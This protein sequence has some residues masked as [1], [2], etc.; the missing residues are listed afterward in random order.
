MVGSVHFLF[1]FTPSLR[2]KACVLVYWNSHIGDIFDI[3]FY[4]WNKTLYVLQR[5][6]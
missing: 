2:Q 3:S 1:L 4:I 5:K 6:A